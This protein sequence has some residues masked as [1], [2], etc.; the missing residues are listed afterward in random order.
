MQSR[1]FLSPITCAAVAVLLACEP[2]PDPTPTPMDAPIGTVPTPAV[3]RSPIEAGPA[4]REVMGRHL[5]PISR[6]TATLRTFIGDAPTAEQAD[7]GSPELAA[8]ADA[9][10]SH[11]GD[12]VLNRAVNDEIAQRMFGTTADQHRLLLT[13]LTAIRETARGTMTPATQAPAQERI[14]RT[15]ATLDRMIDHMQTTLGDSRP[16]R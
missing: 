14:A 12:M 6:A 10:L 9:L 11:L 1:R 3:E 15:V 13:D 16:L 5:D 7:V 4:D 2:Q 8:A